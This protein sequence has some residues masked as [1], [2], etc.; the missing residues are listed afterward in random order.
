MAVFRYE[1]LSKDGKITEGLIEAEDKEEALKRLHLE[2]HTIS[3]LHEKSPIFTKRIGL[4]DLYSFTR[5]LGLLLKGGLPLHRA[6]SLMESQ[7]QNE[8]M[9]VV[10]E[11]MRDGIGQGLS[12]SEAMSSQPSIFPSSLIGITKAGEASGTLEECLETF[13]DYIDRSIRLRNRIKG[14]VVYPC[15]IFGAVTL[16]LIFISIFVIPRI[17]LLYN[18]LEVS[19]PIVTRILIASTTL[20]SDLW[21]IPLS[22]VF[23]PVIGFRVYT[24]KEGV[25][26]WMDRM[27]LRIPLLGELLEKVEM[28]KF[29]LLLGLL[30]KNGVP[31]VEAIPITKEGIGNRYI[32]SKLDRIHQG[33]KE[34]RGMAGLLREGGFCP[35]LVEMVGCGEEVARLDGMLMEASSIYEQEVEERLKGL[36]SMIE[37]M[38]VIGIGIIVGFVVLAMILPLFSLRVEWW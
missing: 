36:T 14:A 12:L 33:L 19:L 5:R 13:S 16:T 28:V 7:S 8:I 27:K 32:S 20:L 18:E 10:I 25:R 29:S 30:I 1:A 37:P 9:K 22:L 26:I 35:Y 3:G 21:W 2:G 4:K 6:L 15:L 24:N 31:L 17:M 34:G 11:R 38:M 23:I